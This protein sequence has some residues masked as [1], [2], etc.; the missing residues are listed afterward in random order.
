MKNLLVVSLT[1]LLLASCT[2]GSS[3]TTKSAEKT[4][5]SDECALGAVK[6]N[7]QALFE[8]ANAGDGEGFRDAFAPAERFAWF[9]LTDRVS[10]RAKGHTSIHEPDALPAYVKE[11]ASS[12]EKTALLEVRVNHDPERRNT[13]ALEVLLRQSAQDIEPPG[14]V[15][16]GGKAEMECDDGRFTVM[17]IGT[18]RGQDA[19]DPCRQVKGTAKTPAVCR[20]D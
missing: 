6:E 16:L 8:A 19:G 20:S 5:P 2:G 12:N 10:G 4:S 18:A 7:L 9:S 3:P 1:L 15:L 11:R 13:A 17:S 14:G